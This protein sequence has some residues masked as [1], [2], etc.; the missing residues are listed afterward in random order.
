ML[1]LVLALSLTTPSQTGDAGN[2]VPRKTPSAPSSSFTQDTS[3]PIDPILAWNALA[4]EAIRKAES[5]PPLAARNLAILHGAL[6]DTV[7]TLNPTYQTY[8]VGLVAKESINLDAALA[9]CGWK[10]LTDLYPNQ[11]A[12]F[13]RELQSTLA[14]IESSRPRSL[15]VDLGK[16]VANRFLE[17]RRGDVSEASPELGSADA[18]DSLVAGVWRATPPRFQKPLLPNLGNLPCFGLKD[19][20]AMKFV[21]PPGLDSEEMRRDLEEVRLVGGIDSKQRSADQSI[22]AWFWND[23]AGTCTPP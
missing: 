17:W 8:R 9:S 22:T 13:D 21:A 16:Y 1:T 18:E 20:K 4:L 11:A 5:P 23:A 2:P 10:V 3:V 6:F 15:G 19:R 7:N 12:T 14:R